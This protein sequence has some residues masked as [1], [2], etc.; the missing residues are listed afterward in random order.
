MTNDLFFNLYFSYYFFIL[1][2]SKVDLNWKEGFS[3]NFIRIHKNKIIFD[4][5]IVAKTA[6]A[7]ISN[8]DLFIFPSFKLCRMIL[9]SVFILDRLSHFDGGNPIKFL[10][11]KSFLKEVDKMYVNLTVLLAYIWK[12]QSSVYD[13][14]G[15]ELLPHWIQFWDFVQN[16]IILHGYPLFIKYFHQFCIGLQKF[17]FKSANLIEMNPFES[18]KEVFGP[19]SIHLNL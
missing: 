1:I 4:Q 7:L 8:C 6:W 2:N 9:L 13:F 5:S 3:T 12:H 19:I 15:K 17:K 10:L 11:H 18:H 16:D 14:V